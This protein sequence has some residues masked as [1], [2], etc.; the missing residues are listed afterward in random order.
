VNLIARVKNI[1]LEPKTE[2]PQ[3]AAEAA[4]AQSIYLNYVLILAAIGPLALLIRMSVLGAV[5]QY[6]IALVVTFLLALIVDAL[7]P[8][9]GGEK[10]F[11][12][13]LKLVAYSYTA[14]WVAG[15]LLLIPILGAIIALLAA[16]YTLYTFYLG[17]PVLKKCPQDKAVGYTI[18]VVICAILLGGVLASLLLSMVIGGG[19]LG[20]GA[21]GTR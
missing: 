14:A 17:V 1:L 4:T 13:S 5:V 2:W 21:L 9:F 20:M 19:A 3:I 18:V 10:N 12:Q 16:I 15:I 7:A 11:V 6:I 8:T